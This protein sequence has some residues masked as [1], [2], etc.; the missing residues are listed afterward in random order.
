LVERKNKAAG[1][2]TPS[3]IIFEINARPT[4][5]QTVM[6]GLTHLIPQR[7]VD[8]INPRGGVCGTIA[9]KANCH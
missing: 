7:P 5:G 9:G 3:G 4:A 8:S 6:L 1:P 2:I